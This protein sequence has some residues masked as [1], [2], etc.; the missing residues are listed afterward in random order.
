MPYIRAL[1][2]ALAA[3]A[4][5][6]AACGDDNE[7][8]IMSPTVDVPQDTAPDVTDRPGAV[9]RRGEDHTHLQA[10]APGKQDRSGSRRPAAPL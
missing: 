5:L 2:A 4:V 9:P 3:G 6:L 10:P 1:G 7:K 8:V